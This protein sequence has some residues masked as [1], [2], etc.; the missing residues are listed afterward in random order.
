MVLKALLEDDVATA[1]KIVEGATG[2]TLSNAKILLAK[3]KGDYKKAYE[4]YWKFNQKSIY[5]D[6]NESPVYQVAEFNASFA[7]SKLQRDNALLEF[8]MAEQQLL[9]V[10]A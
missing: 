5:T 4:L 9:K 8:Q 3:H 2:E 7:Q 1:E 10:K 6:R